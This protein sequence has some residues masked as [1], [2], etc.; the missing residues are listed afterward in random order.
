MNHQ[1]NSLLLRNVDALRQLD[2]AGMAKLG[3]TI[4]DRRKLDGF[5][6]SEKVRRARSLIPPLILEALEEVMTE[7]ERARR[8]AAQAAE[9][10]QARARMHVH[11]R[12]ASLRS[13]D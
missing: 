12:R 7:P 13:K 2:L 8:E 11:H 3:L 6:G 5:R 10:A 1:K 9:D 4:V